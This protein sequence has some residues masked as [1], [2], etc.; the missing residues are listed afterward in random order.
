MTV[1]IGA[2]ANKKAEA[3]LVADKMI[4]LNFP[5]AY[6]YETDDVFK[7]YELTS[8]CAVLT[9]G[10][11]VFAYEIIENSKPIIAAKKPTT[12]KAIAE[13]LREQYQNLRRE[14]IVQQVLEPRKMTLEDY[15]KNQNNLHI[16]VIQQI[17]KRFSEDNI[18]V[19]LI[20]AGYDSGECHLFSI[21]NPGIV[22]D[23]NA[24]GY[25]TIGIGAPH[26]T[27]SMIDSDFKK[28]SSLTEV[29]EMVKK[30]KK[31]SEKAPGVGKQTVTV[32][33]SEK[34]IDRNA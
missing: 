24:I 1:C 15:Y 13:I 14:L 30:A 11:A 21:Y 10:V 6:E 25:A 9:A 18:G 7:I 22:I 32:T 23:N 27:Y 28:T 19:E 33:L 4:S 12:I 5:M 17:E 20:V 8:H 34:G 16:G 26:A 2:L 29:K 31:R 3:I